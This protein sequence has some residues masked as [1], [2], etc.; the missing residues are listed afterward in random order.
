[1]LIYLKFDFSEF[2]D[3]D[4][5]VFSKAKKTWYCKNCDRTLS[6]GTSKS[7]HSIICATKHICEICHESFDLKLSLRKHKRV[8][9]NERFTTKYSCSIC[10][11]M[12][13]NSKSR[14]LHEQNHRSRLRC[15]ACH[16]YFEKS[17]ELKNHYKMNESCDK[18][19]LCPECGKRFR[20]RESLNGHIRR[21]R[22][23]KPHKC[24]LCEKGKLHTYK[25]L[26]TF[27]QRYYI[28]NQIA[29]A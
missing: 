11:K 15:K 1:M 18:T 23:E 17:E 19:H 9:H 14:D 10:S 25:A 29:N 21:H 4:D 7:T 28:N 5:E 27:N 13:V 6:I 2:S 12:F 24:Q 20:L 16:T 22:G 26:M 8:V 3:E